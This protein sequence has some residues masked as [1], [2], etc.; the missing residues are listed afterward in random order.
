MGRAAA[1]LSGRRWIGSGVASRAL[2][3]CAVPLRS[4]QKCEPLRKFPTFFL[5]CVITY[6]CRPASFRAA[7]RREGKPAGSISA[8]FSEFETNHVAIPKGPPEARR[9]LR[10]L[11]NG[12]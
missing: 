3:G 10:V 11:G 6:V 1:G 7:R 12:S 2:G 5:H 9:G 4:G 8:V